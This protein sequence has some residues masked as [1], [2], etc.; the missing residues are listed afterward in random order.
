M[1]WHSKQLS[2]VH[3]SLTLHCLQGLKTQDT[4][5]MGHIIYYSVLL[6]ADFNKYGIVYVLI[7]IMIISMNTMYRYRVQQPHLCYQ[8]ERDSQTIFSSCLLLLSL[9][10]HTLASSRNSTGDMW[11][12]SCK[13][14]TF[15]QWYYLADS[16]SCLYS[17]GA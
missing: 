12:Y 3:R 6:H 4:N 11:S 10:K 16:N 13:M 8:T 14:K 1:G 9:L 15:T 17:L 7:I 2:H 5:I